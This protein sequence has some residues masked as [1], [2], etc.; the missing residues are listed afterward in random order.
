MK[1]KY[2]WGI[3][4]MVVVIAIFFYVG[5][6]ATSGT[7][8][9]NFEWNDISWSCTHSGGF[10]NKWSDSDF[11]DGSVDGRSHDPKY[12]KYS[13]F[14]GFVS[15]KATLTLSAYTLDV[16]YKV[17]SAV[18]CETNISM[19]NVKEISI[20]IEVELKGN[21]MFE[22]GGESATQVSLLYVPLSLKTEGIGI[23]R[24]LNFFDVT[25]K[26]SGDE[27]IVSDSTGNYQEIG[28]INK[29]I[30]RTST[31]SGGH[32]SAGSATSTIKIKDIIITKEE[33][34][35]PPEEE[36]PINFPYLIGGIG[37][38]AIAI[39]GYIWYLKKA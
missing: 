1:N 23:N 37:A 34:P 16:G 11:T 32:G 26:K 17:S 15:N 30:F 4:P 21:G 5:F 8:T 20:P 2:I 6:I 18:I 31:G 35:E 10:V 14:D 9:Y 12:S 27:W 24:E 33:I 19:E 13:S 29:L 38:V 36:T 3:I 39:G 22:T 7:G 25:I 28:N